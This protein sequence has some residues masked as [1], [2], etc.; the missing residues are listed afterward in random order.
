M[1][2]SIDVVPTWYWPDGV[3]RYVSTPRGTVMRTAVERWSRRAPEQVALRTPGGE[4]DFGTL[5]EGTR[6]AADEIAAAI[7]P[8][9]TDAPPRLLMRASWTVG[10]IIGLL[11]GLDAGADVLLIDPTTP[12][13]GVLEIGERHGFGYIVS[14]GRHGSTVEVEPLD[15]LRDLEAHTEEPRTSGR[16]CLL[17][18]DALVLHGDQSLLG[19][20]LA[21]RAFAELE[22]GDRFVV[23]RPLSA[24]EGV[25][26][27]LAPLVVGSTALIP[28]VGG[29]DDGLEF[30]EASGA[31]GLWIGSD[32]ARQ[33]SGGGGPAPHRGAWRWIFVSVDKPW[34]VRE[35][36]RLGRLT[37]ARVLTTFG[38]PATGPVAA[39]PR[40]WSIDEAVG[41]PMTGV[42]LV[43]V[44]Y[45]NGTVAEP[46]WPVLSHAGV[47]VTS[48]FLA[49]G[50]T[51]EGVGPGGFVDDEVFDTG[52]RGRID[53][54][55]F[56]YL[57]S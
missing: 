32:Q 6:S 38:T 51:V 47:G 36:R 19:W 11:G 41:T 9:A 1:T 34:S 40:T 37:G 15:S 22:K 12:W 33:M 21:F 55:G 20:A 44:D 24:W 27:L 13:D 5:H 31:A 53:A 2:K 46:P 39:S 8:L 25:I 4:V 45:V 7:D 23:L 42:D 49:K 35:R 26:G 17:W 28:D 54:N 56:L 52:A 57:V 30:A 18:G 43:P 10:T 14:P 50:I 16:L 29:V 3:P 48:A